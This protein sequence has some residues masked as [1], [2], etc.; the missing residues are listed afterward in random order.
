MV[1]LCRR[2][3]FGSRPAYRQAGTLGSEM[4]KVYAIKSCR[5]N[6]IYVGFTINLEERL[7]RHNK[8]WEKITR[9][10][11]PFKLIYSE[12]CNDRKSARR[13]EKYL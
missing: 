4:Y 11:V 5:R 8:G 12:D 3:P 2:H 1:R 10:Y 7:N 9:A 13:R 6:Y